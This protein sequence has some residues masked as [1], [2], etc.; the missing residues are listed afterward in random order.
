MNIADQDQF[1]I[2]DF[3]DVQFTK[4]VHMLLMRELAEH[5]KKTP[6]LKSQ[7]LK[8]SELEADAFDVATN[9]DLL[10]QE[11]I[12]S[13]RNDKRVMHI[14]AA[15]KRIDTFDVGALDC[16]DCGHPIGR[17]RLVARADARRCV[18]CQ[19]RHD[20]VTHPDT[21]WHLQHLRR[22]T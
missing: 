16:D 10:S 9:M 2:D 21:R 17:N 20:N 7:L 1:T 18:H 13:V 6:E 5:S 15:L 11:I 8:L 3:S 19:E 14:I 4:Y 12:S 22:S